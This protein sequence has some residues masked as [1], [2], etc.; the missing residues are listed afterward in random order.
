LHTSDY[1]LLDSVEIYKPFLRVL[2][3]IIYSFAIAFILVGL[4]YLIAE[5]SPYL[6]KI[7]AYECGFEPFEDAREKFKVSFYIVAI[8]FLIFDV[9]IVYLFP[10]VM[11]LSFLN[12]AAIWGMIFFLI[13]LAVGFVYEILEGAL[14]WV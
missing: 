3:Y 10:W 13:L 4:S 11:A 2:L 8:L 14:A 9:E 6:E 1:S 5:Q 12:A 7:S